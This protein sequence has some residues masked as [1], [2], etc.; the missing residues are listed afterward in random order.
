MR[1]PGQFFS[2]IQRVSFSTSSCSLSP[3]SSGLR[4]LSRGANHGADHTT[5]AELR[6]IEDNGSQSSGLRGEADL[7]KRASSAP[8]EGS[9]F[10]ELAE[11]V[12]NDTAGE[13]NELIFDQ[14]LA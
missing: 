9:A 1:Y 14:T 11:A 4:T 3:G 7:D 10:A 12:P 5:V 13:A 6:V 2:L 8:D